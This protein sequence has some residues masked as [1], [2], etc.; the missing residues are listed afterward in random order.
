MLE[1]LAVFIA[2]AIAVMLFLLLVKVSFAWP[3]MPVENGNRPTSGAGG[4]N[5]II[6]LTAAGVILISYIIGLS[7]SLVSQYIPLHAGGGSFFY[8]VL[9]YIPGQVIACRIANIQNGKF[10]NFATLVS[11][12]LLTPVAILLNS[13]EEMFV[14]SGLNFFFGGFFL[15]YIMTGIISIAHNS[16]NASLAVCLPGM[17]YPL[18]CGIG[19]FWGPLIS[20]S[21]NA[22][23]VLAV[24]SA[25]L[26]ALALLTFS[27]IFLKRNI[28]AFKPDLSQYRL[29]E[30][31]TEV[32]IMLTEGLS[33][34]A[35]A[36]RLFI[37]EKTVRNHISKQ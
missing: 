17:L 28:P 36:S 18:F 10:V 32:L 5:R 3:E 34:Q 31:E 8:P 27:S 25:M 37:S 26:A 22:F 19:G 11:A 15:V 20:A 35:I 24:Y 12:L 13:P 2:A 7:D 23:S 1:I 16:R 9:F 21:L 14:Y 29:T 4:Q 30:R 6:A 33:T